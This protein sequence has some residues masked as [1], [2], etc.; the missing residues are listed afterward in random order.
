MA[1]GGENQKIDAKTVFSLFGVMLSFA[2]LIVTVFDPIG[3]RD[4][5]TK[6]ES[7]VARHDK[8][9]DQ[10]SPAIGCTARTLDRVMDKLDMEMSCALPSVQ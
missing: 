3:D 7:T 5:I 10:R 1:N 9:L 8:K 4:R 6:L 2:M